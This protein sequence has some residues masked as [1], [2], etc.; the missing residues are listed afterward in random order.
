MGIGLN[1]KALRKRQKLT[2]EA[3]GDL[4]GIK[5]STYAAYEDGRN[6]PDIEFL[7]KVSSEFKVPINELIHGT[8]KPNDLVDSKQS[9]TDRAMI[10][11]NRRE[12][13]KLMSKV[14]GKTLQEV[15]NEL[16]ENT[17]IQVNEL[18]KQV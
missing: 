2:Q 8:G 7:Q 16:E 15:L 11:V 12:L 5:R 1:I 10:I 14:Y 4:F 6:E 18:L 17:T 9:I 3:F 13:A